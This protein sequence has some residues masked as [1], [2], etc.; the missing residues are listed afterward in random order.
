MKKLVIS[1]L[2]FAFPFVVLAQ[3]DI[4][5]ILGTIQGI[6][7]LII[8]ILG[9][10]ALAVFIYGIVKFIYSGGDEKKRS[11]AKNYIVYG[12]IGM[13]VL[14]AMWGIFRIVVTTF[15]GGSAGAPLPLPQAP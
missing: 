9:S 12:L 6:V 11:E 14:V 5:T 3:A 10:V 15:F 13:F 7:N 4:T 1:S 2:A 8:P